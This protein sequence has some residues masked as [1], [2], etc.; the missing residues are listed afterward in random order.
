MALI[1]CT[2]EMAAGGQ[3]LRLPVF[4]ELHVGYV[5]ILRVAKNSP[6]TEQA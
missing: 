1:S 2:F 4:R 3:E 5:L 6:T